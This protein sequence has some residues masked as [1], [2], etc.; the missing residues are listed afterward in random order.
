LENL[1]NLVP[2]LAE[3]KSKMAAECKYAEYAPHCHRFQARPMR[4][5]CNTTTAFE[6]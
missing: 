5:N 3:T 4:A 2:G 6:I 1:L